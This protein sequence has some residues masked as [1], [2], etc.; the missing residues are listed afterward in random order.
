LVNKKGKVVDLDA[1]KPSNPE[2]IK[3]LDRLIAEK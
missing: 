2:L 1:L 3:I